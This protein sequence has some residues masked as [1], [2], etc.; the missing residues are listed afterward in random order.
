ME[1]HL[2]WM[3]PGE[4]GHTF[5][6]ANL[7][8]FRWCQNRPFLAPFVCG[9]LQILPLQL[10]WYVARTYQLCGTAFVWQHIWHFLLLLLLLFLLLLP[11]KSTFPCTVHTTPRVHV[12][13]NIVQDVLNSN[14][15]LTIDFG[16]VFLLPT[17]SDI[18]SGGQKLSLCFFFPW[19]A[20]L[21]LLVLW[22]ASI[23]HLA[24]LGGISNVLLVHATPPPLLLLIFRPSAFH[25]RQVAFHPREALLPSWRQGCQVA[26]VLRIF[27]SVSQCGS[28]VWLLFFSK[29]IKIKLLCLGWSMFMTPGGNPAYGG[30]GTWR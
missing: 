27:K 2:V 29:K 12:H 23:L 28:F 4:F 13:A 24:S 11:K 16:F 17:F 10:Y 7:K 5:S 19:L 25:E 21:Y 20:T 22:H 8:K 14:W 3:M 26:L 6:L 15:Q 9:L 1:K 30:D 18:L